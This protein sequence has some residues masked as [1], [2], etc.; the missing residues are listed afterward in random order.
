MCSCILY[1]LLCLRRVVCMSCELGWSQT[2]K[3]IVNNQLRAQHVRALGVPESTHMLTASVPPWP[4]C[5]CLPWRAP[6][7]RLLLP[8]RRRPAGFLPFHIR[9]SHPFLGP[10]RPVFYTISAIANLVGITVLSPRT[11]PHPCPLYCLY[12]ASLLPWPDLDNQ[13]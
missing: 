11:G 2:P 3:T 8:S 10:A 12:N 1:V 9:E 6:S 7:N 5:L 13:T 4:F